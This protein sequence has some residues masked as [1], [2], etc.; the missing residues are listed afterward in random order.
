MVYGSE[1]ITNLQKIFFDFFVFL[2]GKWIIIKKILKFELLPQ[3]TLKNID[4][5]LTIFYE[6]LGGKFSFYI[7]HN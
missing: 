2:D 7:G 6:N 4:L 5:S 3:V 1:K